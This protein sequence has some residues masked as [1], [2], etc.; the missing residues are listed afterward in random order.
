LIDGAFPFI[1]FTRESYQRLDK[2]AAFSPGVSPALCCAAGDKDK[3]PTA[4]D[5]EST[6]APSPQKTQH[7][8]GPQ[9]SLSDQTTAVLRHNFA[10]GA[11]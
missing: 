11:R 7:A 10:M 2:D 9:I 8:A 4:R 6:R 3:D 1:G 5:D